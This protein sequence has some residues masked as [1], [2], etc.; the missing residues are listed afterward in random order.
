MDEQEKYLMDL[1]ACLAKMPAN[2]RQ[3]ALAFYQEYLADA[4]FQ[5]RAEIEAA[6]GTPKTLSRK[7][8]ADQSVQDNEQATSQPTPRSS[9]RTVWLVILAI[10][11]M[12]SPLTFGVALGA[13]ATLLAAVIVTFTLGLTMIVLVFALACAA[14][15][16]MIT[17]VASLPTSLFTGLFYLGSGLVLLGIFLVCAP[18][19]YRLLS[20]LGQ[21]TVQLA[22]NVY[23]KFSHKEKINHE[24]NA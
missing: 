12:T 24:K 23:T 4:G 5:T 14:M 1:A 2:E 10:V 21:W 9:W 17:G 16:L 11:A 7:I 6:L 18:L 3:D 13:I 22:K 8:M 15:A 19:V 20:R